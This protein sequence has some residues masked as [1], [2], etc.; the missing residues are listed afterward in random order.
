MSRISIP[1][2]DQSAKASKPLL[3]AVNKQLGVVPNLMKLVGL[4]AS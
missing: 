2:V 1:T 4:A 3:A